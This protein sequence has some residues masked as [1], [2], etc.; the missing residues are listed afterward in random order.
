VAALRAR[1]R[2]ITFEGGE[3][4]G[5]SGHVARLAKWLKGQEIDVLATREPGGSPHAEVLRK[6]LLAGRFASHGPEA[7]A[8]AFAVARADHLA[9][10]I[11]PA[12]KAGTWVISDRFMDSTRAYQGPAGADPAL[13]DLLDDIVVGQDRPDLTLILDVP[14]D[15]GLKRTEGRAHGPD[16]FERDAISMH[17]ARRRA[18]LDI[19]A[20]NPKRCVVIDTT[21]AKV[22]V[23]KAIREAVTERLLSRP[24]RRN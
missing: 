8:L 15:A 22:V 10:T 9:V 6:M 1:G 17:E 19:A 20:R 7:E 11:R 18:F 2:F 24:R 14:A 16:R 4:A 12:L 21:P 3:G 13:L 23:A 5:K